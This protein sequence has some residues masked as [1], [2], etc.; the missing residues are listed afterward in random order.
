L[1]P[2]GIIVLEGEHETTNAT[3][4]A[5]E[6]HV[7]RWWYSCV[8]VLSSGEGDDGS[9]VY[10]G[11][12]L[13]ELSKQE[14]EDLMAGM[15]ADQDYTSS[16]L[17]DKDVLAPTAPL[18]FDVLELE[19][20]V[21]RVTDFSRH[22]NKERIYA[23]MMFP[24]MGPLGDGIRETENEQIGTGIH[25]NFATVRRSWLAERPHT[26][27][28]LKL[29]SARQHARLNQ[30]Q[31]LELHRASLRARV[32]ARFDDCLPEEL[33][34]YLWIGLASQLADRHTAPLPHASA[35]R[36][37]LKMRL[38]CREANAAVQEVGVAATTRLMRA[39]MRSW[40]ENSSPDYCAWLRFFC[41]W[42]ALSPLDV[43]RQ[44]MH[45]VLK[46]KIHC[47]LDEANVERMRWIL[48]LRLLFNISPKR[49]PPALVRSLR[50]R[51]PPREQRRVVLRLQ[52]RRQTPG[53]RGAER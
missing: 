53:A 34:H 44:F 40:A 3:T 49:P 20:Y 48:F 18:E 51:P 6:V 19:E 29:R 4:G 46:R 17:L 25:L 11:N 36:E 39:W 8:V 7:Q 26:G 5:C 16:A 35:R 22:S 9:P 31:V 21:E 2:K 52:R 42:Y 45:A 50:V 41:S 43:E 28:H 12:W 37:L 38:V 1:T 24:M 10:G 23:T 14:V 33:R 47:Q 30:N 32:H 15:Q 27:P 13:W